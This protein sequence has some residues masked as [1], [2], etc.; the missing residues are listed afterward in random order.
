MAKMGKAVRKALGFTLIELLVVIAI[1]AILAAML[2]PALSQAREKAR[3][4]ACISNLKQIGLAMVMYCDDNNGFMPDNYPSA[5]PYGSNCDATVSKCMKYSS[6]DYWSLGLLFSEK[7]I[8]NGRAFFCK[9]V[10]PY[11]GGYDDASG[12]WNASYTYPS[13]QYHAPT[14]AGSPQPAVSYKFKDYNSGG[15]RD[16]VPVVWD[17]LSSVRLHPGGFNHLMGDGSARWSSIKL[18]DYS[19]PSGNRGTISAFLVNNKAL[20]K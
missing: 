19:L 4:A 9:T 10:T 16:G 6:S 12:G 8:T 18:A 3:Q 17:S 2:L 13:Y 20:L 7:Y 1:I 15:E 14:P 11:V 5:G